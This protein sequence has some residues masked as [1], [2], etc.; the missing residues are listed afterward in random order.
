MLRRLSNDGTIQKMASLSIST[1][2]VPSSFSKIS[3]SPAS[4]LALI[5]KQC[6]QTPGKFLIHLDDINKKSTQEELVYPTNTNEANNN[7][8]NHNDGTSLLASKCHQDTTNET[9]TSSSDETIIPD[10]VL[11]YE[12]QLRKAQHSKKVI[13]KVTVQDH[14]KVVYVDDYIVLVN[15]PAGILTVPGINQHHGASLLSLVHSQYGTT[16]TSSITDPAHMIVHR[17]DMDTSGLVLFGRTLEVTKK[18]Q[19]QFRDR[20]IDKEYECIVTGHLHVPSSIIINNNHDDTKN[21]IHKNDNN[22]EHENQNVVNNNSKNE[23]N[24]DVGVIDLPLQRDHRNPPFMRVST[25]ISEQEAIEAV[26]HLQKH[27]WKKLVRKRPKPSQTIVRQ[28][29]EYGYYNIENENFEQDILVNNDDNDDS[30]RK[31]SNHNNESQQ[32]QQIRLPYTRLRL[33]P[34]T[35]RTHQL[36]VHCAALGYPIVGDP[37][38]SLYGE[39]S[40]AG[41]LEDIPQLWKMTERHENNTNDIS[42]IEHPKNV[43]EQVI[44]NSG[45][46]NIEKDSDATM[47]TGNKDGLECTYAPIPRCPIEIQND[48]MNAYRPNSKAMCLHARILSLHHPVSGQLMHWDVPP[49]F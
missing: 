4:S 3:S 43:G 1:R 45:H 26:E 44:N 21:I 47:I 46:S 2:N 7:N 8:H 20:I 6:N 36:R 9:P 42:C 23:I 25:P 13:M 28:I 38:Y 33:K 18:L 29:V 19:E 39:A 11:Q 34:I 35:G 30:G 10:A 40:A 15:K 14:L 22:D 32:K 49:D 5:W 31:V 37:T 16:T 27:G 17:L 12:R 41:G 24:V 48:W